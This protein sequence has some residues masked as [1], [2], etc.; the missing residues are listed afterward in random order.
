MS[1]QKLREMSM[2]KLTP[3]KS[4][5]S[6]AG[7][8]KTATMEQAG[9]RLRALAYPK[10]LTQNEQTAYQEIKANNDI[11]TKAHVVSEMMGMGIP[12]GEA[13]EAV[14]N[15]KRKGVVKEGREFD[16]A[17]TLEVKA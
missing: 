7:T 14:N 6:M 15:L 2:L 8:V 1:G 3:H 11:D 4:G 12:R 16:G 17:P 10:G 5:I 13:I 9:A